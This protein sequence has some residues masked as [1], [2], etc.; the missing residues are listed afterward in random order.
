M[1]KGD[2]YGVPSKEWNGVLPSGRTVN[3]EIT[4]P[5]Q[6]IANGMAGEI[7]ESCTPVFV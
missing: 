4:N 7:A 2:T 1:H 3:L 6:R 5:A